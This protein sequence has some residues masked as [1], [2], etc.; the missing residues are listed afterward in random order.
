MHPTGS[1][2][3]RIVT[4]IVFSDWPRHSDLHRNHIGR[5]E[6][7]ELAPTL[8]TLETIAAAFQTAPSTLIAQAELETMQ[9]R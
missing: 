8:R 2:T 6:R 4:P 3:D 1:P 7:G 9:T 5:I